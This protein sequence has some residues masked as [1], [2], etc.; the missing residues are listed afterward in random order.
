VT[1][2]RALGRVGRKISNVTLRDTLDRAGLAR[3]DSKNVV[4]IARSPRRGAGSHLAGDASG[5]SKLYHVEDSYDNSPVAVARSPRAIARP[6][7]THLVPVEKWGSTLPGS[8]RPGDL[9]WERERMVAAHQAMSASDAA[10]RACR[11]IDALDARPPH[12]QGGESTRSKSSAASKNA[13]RYGQL[14]CSRSPHLNSLKDGE[15]WALP[16]SR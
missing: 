14:G 3:W 9:R 11:M 13:D 10:P 8:A 6:R 12:M 16:R 1:R 4:Q 7:Y 15:E 5:R 2:S